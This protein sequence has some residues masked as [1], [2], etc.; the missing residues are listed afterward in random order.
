MTHPV[1]VED[2]VASITLKLAGAAQRDEPQ[3]GLSC[4]TR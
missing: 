3:L 1:D 4:T 2:G